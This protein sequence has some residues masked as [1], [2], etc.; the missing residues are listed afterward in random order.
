MPNETNENSFIVTRN[1]KL[2]IP[3][4]KAAILTMIK[5]SSIIRLPFSFNN[6]S[7]INTNVVERNPAEN[8]NKRILKISPVLHHPGPNKNSVIDGRKMYSMP[9]VTNII[10]KAYLQ[11]LLMPGYIGNPSFN[12][13]EVL[14]S[15]T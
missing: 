3:Y 9:N 8:H 13:S 4:D 1:P 15:I 6:V 10:N 11:N 12:L 14:L 2:T 7:G 5:T